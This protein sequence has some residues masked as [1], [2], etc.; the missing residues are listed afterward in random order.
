MIGH[1]GWDTAFQSQ[2][3]GTCH[4]VLDSK[5]VSNFEVIPLRPDVHG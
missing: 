2:R 4:F 1:A 3:D 5:D